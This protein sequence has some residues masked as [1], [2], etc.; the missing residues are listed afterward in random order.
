MQSVDSREKLTVLVL[1]A[2]STMFGV[3]AGDFRPIAGVG[4]PAAVAASGRLSLAAALAG[5]LIAVLMLL[6]PG[7]THR[8]L[9]ATVKDF[10]PQ[11][12]GLAALVIGYALT[13]ETLGFF[14]ATTL[15]LGLGSLL[16]GE[17]RWWSLFALSLP[18]AA[19]LEFTLHGVFG[20]AVTDPLMHALGLIA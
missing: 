3:V 2:A 6:S 5:I 7:K 11:L 14:V 16:L 12:A 9:R 4:E 19:A 10:W 15:F 8:S 13:L 20:L 17:R 18:V 1:L